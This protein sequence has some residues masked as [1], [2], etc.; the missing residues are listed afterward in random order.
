MNHQELLEI[1]EN[2]EKSKT[3]V[4]SLEGQKINQMKTLKS[5]HGCNSIQAAEKK[6][7]TWKTEIEEIDTLIETKNDELQS[8]YPELEDYLN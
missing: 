6:I 8:K 2:I 3:E 7:K 5:E 1:K 4:T